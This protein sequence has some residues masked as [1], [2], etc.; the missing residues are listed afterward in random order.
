M[1]PESFT[2]TDFLDCTRVGNFRQKNYSAEDGIGGEIGL[3]RRN[4]ACFAERKNLGIPFRTHSAEEKNAQNSV[5]W[6]KIEAK[7]S[8]F[9]SKPFCGR[10][11]NSE[12]RSENCLLTKP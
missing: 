8:E 4:S 2:G 5:P 9:S 6:N 12:F 3:F 1:L 7:L 11:N 10:E